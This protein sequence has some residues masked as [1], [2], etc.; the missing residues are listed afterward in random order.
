MRV[1]GI[2]MQGCKGVGEDLIKHKGKPRQGRL[3]SPYKV[4]L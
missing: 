3:Q 4:K 2:G 1:G